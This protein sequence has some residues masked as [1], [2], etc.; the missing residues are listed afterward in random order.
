MSSDDEEPSYEGTR[1]VALEK[2]C[3]SEQLRSIFAYIQQVYL[4][5]TSSTTN[6]PL[7]H[8]GSVGWPSMP[9]ELPPQLR[10]VGCAWF[11]KWLEI[12]WLCVHLV[13]G[14]NLSGTKVM[15]HCHVACY[16]FR[17]AFLLH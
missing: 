13:A 1:H 12:M 6:Y 5:Q 9:S 7:F 3:C 15:L 2:K 14:P 17:S 16:G 11:V 10:F 8:D 4:A